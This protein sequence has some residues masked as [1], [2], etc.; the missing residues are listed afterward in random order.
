MNEPVGRKP[1]AS[2]P[3]AALHIETGM[4]LPKRVGLIIFFLVFGVFGMW[5]AIAPIGSAAYAPGV[6]TV[7]SYKKIIQHLEGGII[8]EILVQNGDHVTEG[9]VLLELDN[10]QPLAQLEIG[11]AQFAALKTIESR[12]LAERVGLDAVRYPP[13]LLSGEL[14]ASTEIQAQNQIFQTRKAALDG[15]REVL[16]QRIG[17]L[18]SRLEGL[19]GLQQSKE[20]LASSY[21]AEL[22]DV[23]ALL[24]QGFAD[25]N[26]L[27]EIE[28][29]HA[30]LR[31][32][33]AELTA[34][35]SSTEIQIGETRLQIL[36][37]ERQFQNE[38]AAQLGEVQS[39]LKD[40]NERINALRD[41]VS[42]TLIRAPEEGVIMGLQFQTVG[43]VIP[44]GTPIA[45]IVPQSAE[46]IIEARVSPYDIDRVVEG[47]EARIRFSS[48]GNSTP[49]IYG[50]VLSLS[51]DSIHDQTTG[52]SFYLARIEV[53]PDGMEDLGSLQLLPGMPADAFI[54]TGSRTFLQYL[55][56]QFSN[57]IARSFIED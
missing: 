38:V 10:T 39:N 42:R 7:K 18:Q 26:R 51:A 54:A 55:F 25:K 44:S 45:E 29:N 35:I 4:D 1:S 36:Q 21:A 23:S 3:A 48:F 46:L 32:E 19:R 40:I 14:D 52:M 57:A 15:S 33:A 24:S 20:D 16:E 12:L 47:Q 49:T 56:K 30:S 28:R 27:R 8:G 53:A 37:E 11:I 31:G 5:A 50:N 6:V 13:E 17:Q 34:T 22:A 9:Q 2:L 43:G 41:V